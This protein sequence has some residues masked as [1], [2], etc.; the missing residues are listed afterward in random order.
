MNYDYVI[1]GN[2]IL[3]ITLA[4]KL[5]EANKD[6]QICLIG[7]S[8]RHGSASVASGAMLNVFGEIE[9]GFFEYAPLRKRFE[10]GFEALK[11]WPDHIKEIEIKSKKKIEKRWGTHILNSAAGTKFEDSLFDYLLNLMQ[12][13][14]F[15]KYFSGIINPESIE[16]LNSQASF[17][18][19]RSLKIG[20]GILDSSQLISAIDAI[21]S[22]RENIS[23]L[24]TNAEKLRINKND[25]TVYVKNENI[26]AKQVILANGSFAQ[27]LIDKVPEIKKYTPRLFFGAGTGILLDR[28]EIRNKFSNIFHPTPKI[29]MRTMDRGHACGLHWLPF[30]S[31]TYLGAS[32][33]VYT[34]PEPYPRSSTISFLL[35]DGLKQL[36]PNIGR[37][38]LKG[39]TYG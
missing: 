17:R 23:I 12:K 39:I 32:S 31:H 13:K 6:S 36:S 30:K 37:S 7:Q 14:N 33:A 19:I 25:F 38:N 21:V 26:I 34:T 8:S 27:L 10:L 24:D 18:T 2:G 28:N 3:G 35:G 1:I 9:E 15:N 20:D 5:S 29:A 16:G 11:M 4:W 22:K